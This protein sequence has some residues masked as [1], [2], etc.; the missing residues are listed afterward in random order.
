VVPPAADTR[1]AAQPAAPRQQEKRPTRKE[2]PRP[3]QP[4]AEPALPSVAEILSFL[5]AGPDAALQ[6]ALQGEQPGGTATVSKPGE[7]AERAANP[8]HSACA[9][10][11]Q[12]PDP[13][14]P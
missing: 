13:G 9:A 11:P 6:A 4:A 3:S 1:P 8:G 5:R 14:Q 12:Q 7:T 2:A 10:R